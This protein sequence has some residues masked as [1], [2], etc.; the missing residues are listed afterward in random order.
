MKFK[1]I[2]NAFLYI[3]LF[4]LLI[5]Y[6]V[7]IYFFE[8]Y[9]FQNFFYTK[10][11]NFFN[12]LKELSFLFL[13]ALTLAISILNNDF[14]KSKL[15]YF[16]YALIIFVF[17]ILVFIYDK[18]GEIGADSVREILNTN[19]KESREFIINFLLFPTY[20]VSVISFILSPVIFAIIFKFYSQIK[21]FE[22]KFHKYILKVFFLSLLIIFVNSCRIF[23]INYGS[24]D[25]LVLNQDSA[26]EKLKHNINF[27]EK[28]ESP[29]IIVYIGESTSAFH[30]SFYG[31]FRDTN[32]PLKDNKENIT[33]LTDVLSA[34]SHT[35]PSLLRAL[36]IAQ[37]PYTDPLV[38]DNE[39]Q[40]I[41]LIQLL[42][43][44]GY[45]TTWFS[46][47]GIAGKFDTASQLYGAKAYK[48][49]FLNF[50]INE[51]FISNNEVKFDSELVNLLENKFK[52]KF[53]KPQAI[54]LHSYAGHFDYCSNI[55]KSEKII[56]NDNFSKANFRDIFGKFFIQNQ[57]QH[58]E[59]IDCYDSAMIHIS[60]NINSVIEIAKKSLKPTIVIYFS[61]HGED[62]FGNTSHDSARHNFKHLQIPFY[63][64]FNDSAKKSL[65]DQY[66]AVQKNKDKPLSLS[67]LSD[68]II[69]LAGISIEKLRSSLSIFK[70]RTTEL[71]PR[72]SIFRTSS[73]GEDQVVN[74]D[75][76]NIKLENIK[77][78][79][80]DFLFRRRNLNTLDFNNR[81]RVCV[82]NA[83]SFI[84]YYESSWLFNCI[85]LNIDINSSENKIYAFKN[86]KT[87]NKL[88]LSDLIDSI[89]FNGRLIL[90]IHQNNLDDFNKYIDMFNNIF[91]HNKRKNIAIEFNSFSEDLLKYAEEFNKNGYQTSL[92]LTTD[93]LK[94][95]LGNS[96]KGICKDINSSKFNLITYNSN[97]K[98]EIKKLINLDNLKTR[99]IFSKSKYKLTDNDFKNAEYIT[100]SLESK[101]N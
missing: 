70:I 69:D 62:V 2:I 46:N 76:E 11:I 29:N 91:V 53:D 38:R 9:E 98:I 82:E 12:K 92:F 64:Y 14:K 30:Q 20:S 59:N 83:N 101:F 58:L 73:R 95:C 41:N 93:L 85:Q 67:W 94:S 3:A 44:K 78:I 51:S 75:K 97:D 71:P 57:G 45:E 55:P 1:V 68:S 42:N 54:F 6:F 80:D 65:P 79:S 74:V 26:I 24:T 16:N 10:I 63:V 60:K 8:N 4:A 50:K 22:F 72:F 13:M 23:V 84:K 33:V 32:S 43:M 56:F 96:E 100:V 90:S 89:K 36:S 47:Q 28:N 15:S 87:N 61:D 99:V 52:D 27:L 35:A 17:L 34:H 5:L 66:Q 21:Q 39:L 18:I 31:Y 37:D 7:P 88:E 19:P 48:K 49:K 77:D 81:D 25:D 40:R 86:E